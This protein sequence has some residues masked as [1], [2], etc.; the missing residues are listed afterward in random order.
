MVQSPPGLIPEASKAQKD[1][2]CHGLGTAVPPAPCQDT[3]ST[4]RRRWD[5]SAAAAPSRPVP[6]RPT[7]PSPGAALSQ[8]S[9]RSRDSAPQPA[10]N[11]AQERPQTKI[12]GL[13]QGGAPREPGG[14]GCARLCPARA[15]VSCGSGPVPA[16]K[17]LRSQFA[18]AD[19]R[20]LCRAMETKIFGS[21]AR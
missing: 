17:E 1:T 16:A 13:L 9:A 15:G 10:M 11:P 21:A 8:G 19:G 2:P 18:A 4:A 3:V 5:R 20:Q 12:A 6:S 14:G 7:A